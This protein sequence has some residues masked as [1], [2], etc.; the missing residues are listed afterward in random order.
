MAPFTLRCSL[1]DSKEVHELKYASISAAEASIVVTILT[2]SSIGVGDSG[3]L[4]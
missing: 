2:F 1:V 4:R 3:S